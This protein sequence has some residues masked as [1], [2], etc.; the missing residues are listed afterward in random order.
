MAA[1]Q[2]RRRYNGRVVLFILLGTLWEAGARQIRYSIPEELDKGSFVG[3]I[4]ENLGL[5]PREL[6]ERGVRIV[7]RGWSPSQTPH[8]AQSLHKTLSPSPFV[9]TS[10][11]LSLSLS[12]K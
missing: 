12:L 10:C 2:K 6:A 7:S 4:A 9:P 11:A 3:N 1:L 8:S 5:E